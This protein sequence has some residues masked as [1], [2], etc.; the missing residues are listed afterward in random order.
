[1]QIGSVSTNSL[2]PVD[3]KNMNAIDVSM[4]KKSLETIE[5]NG[6]MLTKMMEASV[7]PHIGS[8]IDI[9]V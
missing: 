2:T 9:R 6:S 5:I 8:N 4:L 1:M 7:A 3:T